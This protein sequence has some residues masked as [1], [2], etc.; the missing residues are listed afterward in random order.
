VRVDD[1][2]QQ[3]RDPRLVGADPTALL[4]DLKNGLAT[5]PAREWSVILDEFSWVFPMAEDETAPASAFADLE[6]L[7][8]A[9]WRTS[10]S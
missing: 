4:R 8:K 1:D 3:P 10:A 6:G 9:Y 5:R 2:E 7:L